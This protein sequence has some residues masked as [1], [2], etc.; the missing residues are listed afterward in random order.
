MDRQSDQHSDSQLSDRFYTTSAREELFL[1]TL[2]ARPFV[3]NNVQL[4]PQIQT[5][6][7]C[8]YPTTHLED[9]GAWF[10]KHDAALHVVH[11]GLIRHDAC[12]VPTDAVPAVHKLEAEPLLQACYHFAQIASLAAHALQ[13]RRRRRQ[14]KITE[15]ADDFGASV[16]S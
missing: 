14:Q 12:P 9:A 11:A 8:G 3:G 10:R 16:G 1:A 5:M 4:P 7:Y 6:I 15:S 13:Q 2:T